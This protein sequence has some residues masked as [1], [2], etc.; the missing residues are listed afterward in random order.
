MGQT[1]NKMRVDSTILRTHCVFSAYPSCYT[2]LGA[3]LRDEAKQTAGEPLQVNGDDLDAMRQLDTV[4][5]VNGDEVMKKIM[6]ARSIDGKKMDVFLGVRPSEDAK[7][8]A[9]ECKLRVSAGKSLNEYASLF[10]DICEKYWKARSVIG[11]TVPFVEECYVLFASK[12]YQLALRT[13]RNAKLEQRAY[14][15]IRELTPEMLQ[16]SLDY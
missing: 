7:L 5:C 9:I 11:D 2:E 4:E 16:K 6:S 1:L 14:K 10:N 12:V 15:V 13:L 8:L 3:L